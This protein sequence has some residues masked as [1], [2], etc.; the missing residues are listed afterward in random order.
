MYDLM[1]LLL[2][3]FGLWS[4]MAA[5]LSDHLHRRL[6]LKWEYWNH[7]DSVSDW[8]VLSL[9]VFSIFIRARV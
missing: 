6:A 8:T 9:S 3:W 7:V 2:I 1:M 4:S 5:G